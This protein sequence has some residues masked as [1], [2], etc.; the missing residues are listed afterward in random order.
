MSSGSRL[1]DG[2]ME[3]KETEKLAQTKEGISVFL[4]KLSLI[5]KQLTARHTD[6]RVDRR[7]EPIRAEDDLRPTGRRGLVEL[8]D[9]LVHVHLSWLR[10]LL[11][12]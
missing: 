3:R 9:H 5:S 11:A 7:D 8:P 6:G 12:W 4:Q 2:E 10:Q 1:I